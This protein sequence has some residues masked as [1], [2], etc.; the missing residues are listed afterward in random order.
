MKLSI[1]AACFIVAFKCKHSFT[2]YR[3]FSEW[4]DAY[5]YV[6]PLNR[7]VSKELLV[8]LFSQLVD[9]IPQHEVAGVMFNFSKILES[10]IP[11]TTQLELLEYYKRKVNV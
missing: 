1:Q 2:T 5:T 11:Y 6:L 8:L 3:M 9:T 10:N 4:L 7:R